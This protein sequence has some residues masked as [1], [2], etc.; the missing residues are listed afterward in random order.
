MS[1]YR[2]THVPLLGPLLTL[3]ILHRPNR[4]HVEDGERS[5]AARTP[6]VFVRAHQHLLAR[7]GRRLLR[8]Q[9][10]RHP[11][12]LHLPGG[13]ARRPPPSGPGADGR[14][15]HGRA[16]RVL[17]VRSER[18]GLLSAGGGSPPP[19]LAAGGRLAGLVRR[20]PG[21]PLA[22]LA[23]R[24]HPPGARGGAGRP[25]GGHGRVQLG[26]AGAARAGRY[27]RAHLRVVRLLGRRESLPSPARVAR[28]Q[29]RRLQG[30]PRGVS[31]P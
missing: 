1:R 3:C 18:A 24:R 6:L 17:R 2:I 16:L 4:R 21:V 27:H 8:R 31:G 7:P 11:S 29:D 23:G 30:H 25:P 28:G 19:A 14:R 26:R 15:P 12:R 5:G 9:H 10:R 22:G 20:V 13:D